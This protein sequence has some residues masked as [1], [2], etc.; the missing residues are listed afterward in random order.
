MLVILQ[1]QKTYLEFKEKIN[2][3]RHAVDA[4][5]K[6]GFFYMK[7]CLTTNIAAI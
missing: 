5:R 3:R 1:K 7:Q 2:L 4:F 6:T